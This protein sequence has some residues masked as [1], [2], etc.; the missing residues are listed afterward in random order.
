MCHLPLPLCIVDLVILV[1]FLLVLFLPP[2]DEP[3]QETDQHQSQYPPDN[4]C[5]LRGAE[6]KV[7]H[8]HNVDEELNE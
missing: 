5:H 1:I 6:L 7:Q 8:A 2:L 4:G 3:R